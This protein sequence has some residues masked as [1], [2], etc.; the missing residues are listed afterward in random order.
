M[1][2]NQ[3]GGGSQNPWG[4]KPQQDGV[5][6]AFK[7][8]QK[9]F[10]S[11]FGG[12]GGS[13]GSSSGGFS[14]LFFLAAALIIWV[15][16]G[17]Y[18]V[19]PAERGVVQR[20]GK[21]VSVREPGW[22][23]RMRGIETVTK[24][25]VSEVNSVTYQ[26]RVLTSDVNLLNLVFTVQYQFVDP[27]K[28]LFGVRDPDV[29]LQMVS[30][31]AIREVVGRS[32]LAQILVASRQQAT[33]RTKELIQKTLDSYGTGIR[34][35]S[36][37]LTDVQVPEA[38]VPAQRDANKAIAD[39]DRLVKEA[40]AYAIGILPVAEGA[41]TRQLQDAEAY[42]VQVT[43]IATGDAARFNELVG[44]YEAS[45]RVMRERLYIETVEAV[46]KNS[47]KVLIDTKPGGNNLLYLPLD[48]LLESQRQMDALTAPGA[49][50]RP[51]NE[52]ET[53]TVEGRA[54]GER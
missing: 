23:W 40:E 42:R 50:A 30:E 26:A 6:Q 43:A 25:N 18:Q 1:A 11:M 21:F 54:R 33:E 51:P 31:S 49:V 3:P 16:S 8:W 19:N 28:K 34:V 5:D 39:R 20:F 52:A 2:W 38:V 15:L 45:P 41:A 35:T 27:V 32:D 7:D 13:G 22:G 48:K 47:K 37:N 17:F 29:T 53:V 9:K 4:R 14:P 10:E 46:L 36:V 24:V 12:G 44:A